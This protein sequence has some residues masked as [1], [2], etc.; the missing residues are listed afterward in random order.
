[1]NFPPIMGPKQHY[2]LQKSLYPD[3][4]AS[5]MNPIQ[6]LTPNFCEIY[7]YNRR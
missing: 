4:N 1:M 2:R 6:I 3:L 7:F 5:H